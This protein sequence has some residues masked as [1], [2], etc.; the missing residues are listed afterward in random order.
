LLHARLYLNNGNGDFS[1]GQ[2]L[3]FIS[4]N[5]SCLAVADIDKDGFTDVFIGGRGVSGQYGKPGRSFLL[6]NEKGKLT[7]VTPETLRTAGMVTDACF[8]D[9]NADGYSDLMIVGEWMPV[10]FFLNTRGSFSRKNEIPN[11]A[12]WWSAAKAADLDKDGDMDF[13]LGNWGLNSRFKAS[14]QHPM[15]LFVSDFDKNGASECLITYFWP[16]GKSHLYPTKTELTTQIP[17]LKKAFLKYKDYPGKSIEDVLGK[18]KIE[19]ATQ[20]K[21]EELHSSVLWNTGKGQFKLQPLPM[22]AQVAPV[23]AI[24]CG[25]FNK[26]N[27]PDIFLG[28]NMFDVKPDVG[29]LDAN[30][31]VIL[32]GDGGG[33]FLA[34]STAE[35][36]INIKGQ[37][38]DAQFINTKSGNHI[39]LARNNEPLLLYQLQ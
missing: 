32:T 11:S 18:D 36:G 3:N 26:D 2:S 13:V 1:Q 5:S 33:N 24:A 38:R 37:V 15:H 4:D 21:A 35:T 22:S 34:A 9:I 10:T 6:R 7:D 29:R 30:N 8:T 19:N 16:D 14:N 12:G 17:S 27:K 25:D 31:G 39:I 28:G 23:Y 20:L